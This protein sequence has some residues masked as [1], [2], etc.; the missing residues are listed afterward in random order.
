MAHSNTPKE[1]SHAR[2][3]LPRGERKC[4]YCGMKIS[5]K[6]PAPDEDMHPGERVHWKDRG[7]RYFDYADLWFEQLDRTHVIDGILAQ[8]GSP[9][10]ED[11]LDFLRDLIA[12]T[13]PGRH[14]LRRVGLV[15]QD[16]ALARKM[17]DRRIDFL[18]DFRSGLFFFDLRGGHELFMDVLF[19]LYMGKD[20][21]TP[22][23]VSHSYVDEGL[24]IFRSTQSP[25][26][27][28]GT[29][30]PIPTWA[31]LAKLDFNRRDER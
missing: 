23:G 29:N 13:G 31:K 7:G 22:V 28:I 27:E 10:D 18:A 26:V 11:S 8:M 3:S 21:L 15:T 25:R 6:N 16:M 2:M 24:G 5:Y 20:A 19:K 12:G 1:A 17:L 4:Y 14:G 30:T 9:L